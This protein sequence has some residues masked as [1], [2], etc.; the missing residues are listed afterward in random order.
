MV[1]LGGI[2]SVVAIYGLAYS[3]Q[4]VPLNQ[5][6][7]K[8]L[9]IG[10]GPELYGGFSVSKSLNAP[11]GLVR[12]LYHGL[13]AEYGGI[14][15]LLA[16]RHN[17]LFWITEILLSNVLLSIFAW[18]ILSGI[19]SA[20]RRWNVSKP[21]AWFGIALSLLSVGFPLIYWAPT[22]DKLWLL[23]LAAIP[24]VAAFAFR[25]GDFDRRHR[26]ILI[27]GFAILVV[28]EAAVNITEAFRDHLHE[29]AHL[30]EASEFARMLSKGD[31]VVID[32]DDVSMLW[33]AIW[34][35]GTDPLVL[36]T[37]TRT[38]AAAWLSRAETKKAAKAG[39]LFFIGVLDHDK[40]GWDAFLARATTISYAEFECYRRNSVTIRQFPF[41][42]RPVTIR[43]LVN[44]SCSFGP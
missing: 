22:Y 41:P 13:P 37:S 34:S 14:R 10:G 18:I 4:D 42:I 2:L 20:V 32:F 15:L 39:R 30:N 26:G 12:N 23:P 43:Q 35:F 33:L 11:L 16:T 19:V 40:Q 6:P 3:S 25:F 27:G 44:E 17:R 29:T 9:A 1:G 28:V 21:L 24:I 7:A 38:Q 8:F 5:M 36:P 31:S